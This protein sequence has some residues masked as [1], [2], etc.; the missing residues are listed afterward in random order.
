[1]TST[2]SFDKLA[3][4]IDADPAR[5][6]RVDEH[7]QAILAAMCLSQLRKA[8]GLTQLQLAEQLGVSQV[9]VSRIENAD[10]T[11][12]STLR[13]YVDALGGHLELRAVFVDDTQP[14]RLTLPAGDHE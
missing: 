12:L 13:R 3:A 7:K 5:R 6:A 8:R 10:D 2:K 11:Q 14:V 9:D 1:M 4:P